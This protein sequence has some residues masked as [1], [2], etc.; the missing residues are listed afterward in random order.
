MCLLARHARERFCAP[1][2]CAPACVLAWACAC[3]RACPAARA[4]RTA[5]ALRQAMH[6]RSRWYRPH[7]H[8]CERPRAPAAPMAHGLG[9]PTGPCPLAPRMPVRACGGV[10]CAPLHHNPSS[11]CVPSVRRWMRKRIPQWPDGWAPQAGMGQR[12]AGQR[13]TRKSAA[14]SAEG[15][16][17]AAFLRLSGRCAAF[18]P[19]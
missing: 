11:L 4:G 6:G 8:R 3:V 9:C 19:V 7:R 16:A 15:R 2:R 10:S 12:G 5:R 13:P 17:V 14:Q 1:T 18:I